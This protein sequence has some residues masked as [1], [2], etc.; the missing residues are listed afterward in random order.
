M[1]YSRRRVLGKAVL[2]LAWLYATV[3]AIRILA[4]GLVAPGD[5]QITPAWLKVLAILLGVALLVLEG[6]WVGLFV[7]DL[8]RGEGSQYLL[9]RTD[10]GTARISLRAIRA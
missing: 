3:A 8:L 1:E 6:V 5:L 9:S 2:F 4:L 10:Q 7:R